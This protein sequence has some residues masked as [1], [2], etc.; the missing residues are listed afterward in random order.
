MSETFSNGGG[1]SKKEAKKAAREAAAAERAEQKAAKKAEREEEAAQKK[2]K[3]RF[4]KKKAAEATEQA[5]EA[6]QEG[7]A[8]PATPVEPGETAASS[9]PAKVGKEKKPSK[10][11]KLKASASKEVRRAVRPIRSKTQ[12]TTA[13]LIWAVFGMALVIVAIVGFWV[14][15]QNQDDSTEITL[16]ITARA[17]EQGNFLEPDDIGVLTRDDDGIAAYLPAANAD[18]LY[19]RII[20]Q[21]VP[22]N[23]EM[24]LYMFGEASAVPEEGDADSELT[25]PL[26]FPGTSDFSGESS[27][28]SIN[29]GDR[30]VVYVKAGSDA[31][32]VFDVIDVADVGSGISIAGSYEDRGEWEA[33]LSNYQGGNQGDESVSYEFSLERVDTANSPYPIDCWKVRLGEIY[34]FDGTVLGYPR[35]DSNNLPECPPEWGIG[36]D[37]APTAAPSDTAA[38]AG[39]GGDNLLPADPDDPFSGIPPLS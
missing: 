23:T 34:G 6:E 38:P 7:A 10:S 29:P 22:E 37:S 26:N 8:A 13:R 11:K 27:E 9:L 33:R 18:S 20:L 32:R 25:F 15:L 1:T 16:L 21:D 14:V 5:V 2:A 30:V 31:K 12:Q 17:L 24:Q 4:G 39:A 36:E 28:S 19:G 3:K 35:V